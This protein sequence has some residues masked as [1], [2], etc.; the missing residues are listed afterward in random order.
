MWCVGVGVS[1]STHRLVRADRRRAFVGFIGANADALWAARALPPFVND[2]CAAPPYRALLSGPPRY[3]SRVLGYAR[4]VLGYSRGVLGYFSRVL[5]YSS[6]VLGYSRGVL[7][8][9]REVLRFPPGWSAAAA[10]A[11]DGLSC[12]DAR[13]SRR[14]RCSSRTVREYP[15]VPVPL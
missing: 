12:T 6:S 8:Y 4:R 7:G 5:G 14:S 2:V 15:G 1:L 13:T 3:F 11:D 9:S 10:A